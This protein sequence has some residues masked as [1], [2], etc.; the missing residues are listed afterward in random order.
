MGAHNGTYNPDSHLHSTTRIPSSDP[1]GHHPR[2]TGGPFSEES[3]LSAWGCSR[4]IICPNRQGGL[5]LTVDIT[6]DEL[7]KTMADKEVMNA[8][9]DDNSVLSNSQVNISAEQLM[10]MIQLA[11]NNIITEKITGENGALN[12]TKQDIIGHLNSKVEQIESEIY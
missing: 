7:V 1:T 2:P 12:Q 5:Y 3:Y 6:W 9:Q 11:L 4:H 10:N 8:A